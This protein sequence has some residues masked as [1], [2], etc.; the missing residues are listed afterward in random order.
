LL[1]PLYFIFVCHHDDNRVNVE[2][3]KIAA[4]PKNPMDHFAAEIEKFRPAALR[5]HEA[6]VG[7]LKECESLYRSLLYAIIVAIMLPLL[8]L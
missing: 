5:Q 8:F 6:L 4:E 3:K 7:E 1:W 2:L